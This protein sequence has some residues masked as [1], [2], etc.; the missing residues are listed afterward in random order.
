LCG[1][2]SLKAYA[3]LIANAALFVGVDSG[4]AHVANALR[5]RGVIILGAYRKFPNYFPYSGFYIEPFNC[6]LV[7]ATPRPASEVPVDAVIAAADRFLQLRD[8]SATA[9]AQIT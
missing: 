6:A 8:S 7:R 9:E 3:A 5:V 4:F 1:R 2:G